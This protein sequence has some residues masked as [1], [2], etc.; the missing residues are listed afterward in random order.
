MT[1]NLQRD[2]QKSTLLVFSVVESL[3]QNRILYSLP[4]DSEYK[5]N[6]HAS[7]VG[8]GTVNRTQRATQSAT[9]SFSA[10]HMTL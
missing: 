4:L 1:R 6:T 10:A 3:W 7:S 2:V 9:P 5:K 8:C